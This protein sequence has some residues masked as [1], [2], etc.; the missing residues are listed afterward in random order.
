M[1]RAKYHSEITRDIVRRITMGALV[2]AG[3]RNGG[4]QEIAPPRV[5]ELPA[6]AGA[7]YSHKTKRDRDAFISAINAEHPGA[8]IIHGEG[9]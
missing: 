9:R 4:G 1:S 3:L 5:V 6:K 7:V 8:A 2:I